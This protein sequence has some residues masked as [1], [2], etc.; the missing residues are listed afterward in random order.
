MSWTMGIEAKGGPLLSVRKADKVEFR[1][2]F[3]GGQSFKQDMT[4]QNTEDVDKARKD[5]GVQP[6]TS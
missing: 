2:T 5:C 4:P 6:P 1:G 3:P